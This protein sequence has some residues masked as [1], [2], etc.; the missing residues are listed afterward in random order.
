MR[1]SNAT[2]AFSILTEQ[3]NSDIMQ[4][5]EIRG[6]EFGAAMEEYLAH[7]MNLEQWAQEVFQ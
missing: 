4:I 3:N 7:G 6:V 2:P 5:M 1:S